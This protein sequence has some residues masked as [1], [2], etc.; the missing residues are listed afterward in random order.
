[1]KIYKKFQGKK[2]DNYISW[3]HFIE[4][5]INKIDGSIEFYFDIW[6]YRTKDVN[7]F[8]FRW[9]LQ[10]NWVRGYINNHINWQ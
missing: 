4:T 7:N 10:I 8:H 6:P 1:M 5:G 3:W 9:S 2:I